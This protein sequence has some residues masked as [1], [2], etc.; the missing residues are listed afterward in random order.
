VTPTK[1]QDRARQGTKLMCK[2]LSPL[3]SRHLVLLLDLKR[4]IKAVEEPA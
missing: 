1:C 2:K 4:I 3:N